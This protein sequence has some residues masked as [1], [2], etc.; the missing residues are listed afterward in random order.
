MSMTKICQMM[1]WISTNEDHWGQPNETHE[2][3]HNGK[4]MRTL[5]EHVAFQVFK[6]VSVMA[7]CGITRR[8]Q[9]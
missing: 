1:N 9:Q 8:V 3:Q 5:L 2:K 7:A 4:Q 6:Y